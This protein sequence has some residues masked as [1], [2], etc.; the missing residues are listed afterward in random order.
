MAATVINPAIEQRIF[1]I[2]SKL[3]SKMSIADLVKNKE[4]FMSKRSIWTAGAVVAG[5]AAAGVIGF[6]AGQ[7]KK[8][9]SDMN[10]KPKT[11]PARPAPVMSA[12]IEPQ[13][14]GKED[15]FDDAAED[16]KNSAAEV[17]YRESG[18]Y[19]DDED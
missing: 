14:N 11:E 13:D 9:I 17:V 18:L 4:L 8:I 6:A 7:T 19:T 16:E 10:K 15:I 5:I 2:A 1:Y 12:G 3:K